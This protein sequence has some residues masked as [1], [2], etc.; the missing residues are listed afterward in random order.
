MKYSVFALPLSLMIATGM[1]QA[2]DPIEK[3]VTVTASIPTE[4]FSIE[5]VG[6]N[7]MNDPQDMAWNSTQ[8]SLQPIRKQLLV[9]STTGPIFGHLLTPAAITSGAD[10]IALDVVV[11]GTPLSL[12]STEIVGMEQAAPGA[13][14]GFE[15]IAQSAGAAGYAPGNYQGMVNMLFETTTD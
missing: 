1:A 7:W 14:V 4:S 11:A 12:T 13:V 8:Q 15:I 3:Q 6:G 2:A 9:R 10:N 5:P